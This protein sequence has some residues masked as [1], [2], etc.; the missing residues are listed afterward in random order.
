MTNKFYFIYL[1]ISPFL[2]YIDVHIHIYIYIW[3][4]LHRCMYVWVHESHQIFVYKIAKYIYLKKYKQID[5]NKYLQRRTNECIP[6]KKI[7]YIYIYIYIYIYTHTH[8]HTN[9]HIEKYIKWNMFVIT[10]DYISQSLWWTGYL[11][12]KWT[13]LH[14]LQLWVNSGANWVL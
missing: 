12:R 1:W 7:L 6:Y 5:I 13:R 11:C 3:A 8:T 10:F 9:T 2:V 14:L 4:W